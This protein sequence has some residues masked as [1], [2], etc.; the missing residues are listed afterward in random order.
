MPLDPNPDH[1]PRAAR[2]DKRVARWMLVCGLVLL[3]VLLECF[4]WVMQSGVS[5]TTD[6]LITDDTKVSSKMK[7][8]AD[9]GVTVTTSELA[10]E[11][12]KG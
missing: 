4:G 7:K 11:L 10:L 3:L 5:K 9:L 8:A 1:L 12:A 6:L 2:R